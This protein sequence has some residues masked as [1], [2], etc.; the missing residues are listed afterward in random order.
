M[1]LA[2]ML[3]K[4][5]NGT[6]V[7]LERIVSKMAMQEGLREARI[8]EYIELFRKARLLSFT[9]GHKKWKYHPESEWELF[10]INV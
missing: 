8:W 10:N 5:K 3:K 7:K 6:Q 9:Q 1:E 4:A 2:G